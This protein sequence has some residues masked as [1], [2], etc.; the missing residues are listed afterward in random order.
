M[1]A[2][3]AT[4]ACL[5]LALAARAAVASVLAVPPAAATSGVSA[6]GGDVDAGRIPSDFFI[7]VGSAA[8]QVEGAWNYS[9]KG[10][11]TTDVAY[12][13]R[14]DGGGQV[15]CDFF[16]KYREDVQLLKRLGVSH[17][18]FSIAWARLMPT[19]EPGVVSEDGKKFYS[20]LIDELRNNNIEPLVTLWHVDYPYALEKSIGG[21]Q[22]ASMVDYFE[23]YATTAFRLFG[24]R[25]RWWSTLNEP[26]MFCVYGAGHGRMGASRVQQGY[27]EYR[28]GHHVL[29]AHARAYRAYKRDF[30][31]YGGKVGLTVDS[32]FTRPVT[33]DYDDVLAAERH[34]QF[35]VGWFLDPILGAT[36]DYPPMMRAAVGDGRL[37]EFTEHE[38]TELRGSLDYIGLNT[39]Y[40]WSA[41]NGVPENAGNPSYERDQGVIIPEAADMNN[42]PGGFTWSP[43]SL[44]STL[45]W[46]RDRYRP[47][48]PFVIT[49]NGFSTT[50]TTDSLED[51]DRIAYFSTWMREMLSVMRNDKVD[52]AG[53]FVWTLLDDFEWGNGYEPKLGLVHVDFD[54]PNRTR[55]PK[56]S[57]QFIADVI[58]NGTVPERNLP[59]SAPAAATATA[60]LLVALLLSSA[61]SML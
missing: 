11:S 48:I 39:Y 32:Y 46:M 21:W 36:G 27:S 61:Y 52:I 56:A 41:R 38:K 1:R 26:H 8:Y 42:P 31:H 10:L 14:P 54:S 58:A 13:S 40:G 60:P 7:G 50:A 3:T 18:R 29:L 25:V 51:N 23:A 15:A 57:F 49:E 44:R 33:T 37:P 4:C 9:D 53:Y 47:S 16:H 30:A 24:D 17:Y 45:L 55:T 6:D 12:N 5:V 43:W 19:G 28:C 22:N 20:D 35:E 2:A 59:S 34:Q